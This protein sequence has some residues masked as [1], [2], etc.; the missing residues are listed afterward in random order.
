MSASPSDESV[1]ICNSYP[2]STSNS[3]TVTYTA[4]IVN[5]NPEGYTYEWKINNATYD[6]DGANE[7]AIT[8]YW[9]NEGDRTVTCIA[10]K[11]N[12]V[13]GKSTT[14][15][16]TV[17]TL[18]DF[19]IGSISGLTVRVDIDPGNNVASIDWGDDSSDDITANQG[20]VYHSYTADGSYPITVY[21]TSSCS[22][23]TNVTVV[24]CASEVTLTPCAV[25]PHTTGYTDETGGFETEETEGAGVTKVR[26][27]NGNEYNV[28]QIGTGSD[29]QCWIAENLRATKYSS[30]VDATTSYVTV[31]SPN[32]NPS[33]VDTYGYL[34][35]W[36]VA[37][38]DVAQS[39]INY[40]QGICP[41]GW[42]VPSESE[43]STLITNA[44]AT[45]SAGKLA[46]GCEWE[47]ISGNN[48]AY[49]GNYN[50]QYRNSSGFGA[51]PAGG[52]GTTLSNTT[53]N[54]LQSYAIFWT[55]TGD[56]ANENKFMQLYNSSSA[57]S[58]SEE[59]KS[60]VYF[61]VRCLRNKVILPS[62][63]TINA[64]N[65]GTNTATIKGTVAANGND[66]SA[67]GFGWKSSTAS[68][69]TLVTEGNGVTVNGENMAY[70]LTSLT[71]STDYSYFAFVTTD[72][73]SV[74]GDTLTFTSANPIL[75]VSPA[76]TPLT[77]CTG[78]SKTETYT[79]TVR[80]DDDNDLTSNYSYS[81]N[82]PAGVQHT[83]H[84]NVCTVVYTSSGSFTI[85]CEATSISN[86][87]P[88]DP[89]QKSISIENT[90]G[91]AP[92]LSLCAEG[93]IVSFKNEVSAY[94]SS[95]NWGDGT[96]SDGPFT[97]GEYHEYESAGVYTIT[98][99]SYDGCS[100]S[101][102]L[103]L[104][105]AI[106]C[107]VSSIRTNEVGSGTTLN[108]VK[109][110]ENHEYPVVQIG[111]QC[112]MAQNLRT[113]KFSNNASIPVFGTGDSKTTPFYYQ[114]TSSDFPDYNV[115]SYGLYY[116]RLAMLFNY[117]GPTSSSANP[118][119]DVQ[120]VCPDGWHIPS[121]T[122]WEVLANEL[123][124]NINVNAGASNLAGGCDW[125]TS[126]DY[127]Y[128]PGFYYHP[129]RNVSGFNA[130]PAG[131][132]DLNYTD[133]I[134]MRY[135]QAQFWTS[136]RDF[137][138]TQD[139]KYFYFYLS[140]GDSDFDFFSNQNDALSVRCLRNVG[141]DSPVTSP[142]L[143]TNDVTNLGETTATLNGTITKPDNVN[144]TSQGFEWW[145]NGSSNAPTVV[146]TTGNVWAHN[147][148]GLTSGTDY[149]YRTFATYASGTVYG[150]EVSF[151]TAQLTVSI[152]ANCNGESTT[153]TYTPSA[154]V[155]G[156]D[157]S[158]DYNYSWDVPSIIE[159][160]LN[161][162]TCTVTYT[163]ANEY[164]VTCTATP[165]SS[166]PALAPVT[167]SIN[168][169]PLCLVTTEEPNQIEMQS[170]TLHGIVNISGDGIAKGFAW[171]KDS[172]TEFSNVTVTENDFSYNL[173]DLIAGNLYTYKA[174]IKFA[175]LTFYGNAQSFT[176]DSNT[177]PA[178]NF[179]CGDTI[180]DFDG[181]KYATKEIPLNSGT[182]WMK[183]NLRTTRYADG[184]EIATTDYINNENSNINDVKSR[185]YLYKWTAVMNVESISAYDPSNLQGICPT[186]W[187]VPTKEEW[188]GLYVSDYQCNGDVAR[189]LASNDY[190]VGNSYG[191]P[192]SPVHNL[193]DNNISD[194]SA[195]PSGY[196]DTDE[197]E[198]DEENGASYFWTSSKASEWYA[199]YYFMLSIY[200]PNGYSFFKKGDVDDNYNCFSVRCVRDAE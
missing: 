65:I 175:N 36:T 58:F 44:N 13:L 143:S 106:P 128:D 60:S 41:K 163:S 43:F 179:T 90:V 145:S 193:S 38:K 137:L 176:T 183:S 47:S 2:P 53:T 139:Q 148:D 186:G 116:N 200:W 29:A 22:T 178:Q 149:T 174:F 185:G 80:D 98:S 94:V 162:N 77:I 155:N 119:A 83:E 68:E 164:V 114:A 96:A 124:D 199:A 181:N 104:G 56:A 188:E 64:E 109:D 54:G 73:G 123:K 105:N 71:A 189:A 8:L 95:I 197:E 32:N 21:S 97:T 20:E 28:V 102:V 108:S 126:T 141:G 5:D 19:E 39:G 70:V 154:K 84:N 198:F 187:H 125:K 184:T 35:S 9:Q 30:V 169:D 196:Y 166:A 50:Y 132:Y 127:G 151:T 10:T 167:S 134:Y 23:T 86:A 62:V 160:T 26:D 140:Y 133:T 146:N 191:D 37:T 93:L 67:Q 177:E 18:P 46:K 182:C 161:G 89:V 170:A 156:V 150:E 48:I 115:E 180:S 31:V 34:Y 42:H 87:T 101:K 78:G 171:K 107:T 173:T 131:Q 61:S 158:S 12:V 113:K 75:S 138:F 192:C 130:L 111:S 6:G 4:T 157:V 14:I 27:Q 72:A 122:E 33:N 190:W 24:D 118:A 52:I 1:L 159:P 136:S 144:I 11:G 7:S 63:T 153:V 110:I 74:Y 172:D 49:P 100:S 16:V 82:V 194:F 51:L 40:V 79:A 121:K 85:S 88:L 92:N 25:T 165:N 59:S 135:K 66:I 76:T 57:I 91:N 168:L 3:H 55:S 152:V 129:L 15:S 147:L 81:W 142:T 120:G 117:G 99:S 17:G 45:N 69:Y 103:T 195:I 112:W